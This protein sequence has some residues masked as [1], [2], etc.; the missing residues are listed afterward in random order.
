MKKILIIMLV[1][2]LSL[3][4]SACADKAVT[5]GSGI[6]EE[7]QQAE[8]G[9][10]DAAEEQKTDDEEESRMIEMTLK[11]NDEEV[12]V[13]WEDNESVRALADIA[14]K[15]P[16]T[17]DTSLY[18]GFEQV[19]GLGTTLPS[20]DVNTTTEPGDIVLYSGSNIVVF[21][22]T[23]SWAYTRLGHIEGRSQ[24]ELRD[25]L[26]GSSVEIEIALR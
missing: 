21:F 25:M 7:T 14:A 18:G 9:D 10:A 11:I 2:V 12:N 22:G 4:S 1:I 3:I 19:G 20:N 15:G 6:P 5:Q 16:V 17:I 26:G 24:D 13:K 8:T 23:N